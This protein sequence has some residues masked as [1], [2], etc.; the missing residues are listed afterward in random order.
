MRSDFSKILVERERSGST[1]GYISSRRNRRKFN[2]QRNFEDAS[3]CGKIKTVHG[4]Y[5]TKA[6]NENLSPLKR[7]LLS[8]V[9]QNWD[10]VYSEICSVMDKDN[11]VQAHIFQH[12]WRYVQ[13]DIIKIEKGIP[14]ILARFKYHKEE[15]Y[16]IYRDR[17]NSSMMWM[18]QHLLP[19]STL[20]N[21]FRRLFFRV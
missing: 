13:K 9:G 11:T 12:L 6:L 15:F 5:G 17:N 16:P 21:Y 8:R 3:K 10:K 19:W 20:Q 14:Y 1:T 4:Y 2:D 18:C 7:F